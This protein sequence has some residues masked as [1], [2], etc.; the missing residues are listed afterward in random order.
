MAGGAHPRAGATFIRISSVAAHCAVRTT[1]CRT[2]V[3]APFSSLRWLIP[4]RR[5]GTSEGAEGDR[6]AAGAA[7]I[8]T[9]LSFSAI[10]PLE[11]R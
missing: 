7:S 9:I 10:I 5:W 6:T 8:K 2:G 3:K 1:A 4:A 11:G